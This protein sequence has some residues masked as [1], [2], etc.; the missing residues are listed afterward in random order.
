MEG[1]CP[2]CKTD[3]VV[4]NI[5]DVDGNYLGYDLIEQQFETIKDQDLRYGRFKFSS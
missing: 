5:F 1:N 2:I 4:I 3:D